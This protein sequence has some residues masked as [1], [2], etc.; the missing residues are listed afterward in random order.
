LAPRLADRIMA[1][2]YR[3]QMRLLDQDDRDSPD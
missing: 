1:I 3:D 2:Y